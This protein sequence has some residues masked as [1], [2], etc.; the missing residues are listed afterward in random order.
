ME[1]QKMELPKPVSG[2]SNYTKFTEGENRIRIIGEL[3]AGWETW[4][5]DGDKNR[6]YRQQKPFKAVEMKEMGSD[7]KQKQF[8]AGLVWNYTT[9]Q[10]EVMLITQKSIKEGIYNASNDPDWRSYQTYDI[11]ITRTGSGMDTSYGFMPK[12]HSAFE[13]DATVK[14]DLTALYRG[15]DPF[16]I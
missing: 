8:Y 5:H 4:V 6:P 12:P 3:I 9:N 2:G 13:G 7:G 14:C 11:V 15:E 10:N 16:E 1:S